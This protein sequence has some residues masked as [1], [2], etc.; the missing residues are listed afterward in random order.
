MIHWLVTAYYFTCYQHKYHERETWPGARKGKGGHAS[1]N[2]ICLL[3]LFLQLPLASLQDSKDVML[4][5]RKG[6]SL[7]V[8]MNCANYLTSF[9]SWGNHSLWVGIM[10][11]SNNFLV[12]CGVQSSEC[13][14]WQT[15]HEQIVTVWNVTHC[16]EGSWIVAGKG[17]NVTR[18]E[19]LCWC[20]NWENLDRCASV[21]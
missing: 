4:N 15:T 2:I 16:R 18:S 1:L 7:G 10:R 17:D 21:V 3:L 20:K 13:L 14:L 9:Y 6:V 5:Y 8:Y 11:T 19:Q 12:D